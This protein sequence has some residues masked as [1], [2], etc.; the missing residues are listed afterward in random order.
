MLISEIISRLPNLYAGEHGIPGINMVNFVKAEQHR[1]RLKF[2]AYDNTQI[3]VTIKPDKFGKLQMEQKGEFAP[4]KTKKYAY[5]FI[6]INKHL[7][8][9]VANGQMDPKDAEK[10]FQPTRKKL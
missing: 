3:Y 2:Y 1:A 5:N 9:A 10:K 6:E 8:M 7:I 4:G